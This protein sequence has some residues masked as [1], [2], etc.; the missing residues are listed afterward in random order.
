[1]PALL[2][3]TA[4]AQSR[5]GADRGKVQASVHT[6]SPIEA[7]AQQ[8]LGASGSRVPAPVYKFALAG[9]VQQAAPA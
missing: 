2:V 4:E 6:L 9:A 7:V 5:Q 8:G 3:A 1:M